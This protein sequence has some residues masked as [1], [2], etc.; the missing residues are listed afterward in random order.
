M[1]RRLLDFLTVLSLLLCVAVAVMWVRSQSIHESVQGTRGSHL[2]EVISD[3]GEIALRHSPI[4][5]GPV[6]PWVSHDAR[7]RN[8]SDV[9]WE[10]FC[11]GYWHGFGYRYEAGPPDGLPPGKHMETFVVPHG[12]IA[13]ASSILPGGWVL[14]RVLARRRRKAGL[15]SSCGYDLRA[16]P[17]RC[18]E[19]GTMPAAE[20]TT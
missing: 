2:V 7:R 3:S 14:A 6:A 16:T 11:D 19:C 4:T 1:M 18:P 20:P 15:C 8:G 10:Q 13:S 17:G 9:G 12:A 5:G